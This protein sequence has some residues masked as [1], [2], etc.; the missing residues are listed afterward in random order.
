[1]DLHENDDV[2]H[3]FCD[4][5]ECTRAH[6]NDGWARLLAEQVAT[7][8]LYVDPHWQVS[9]GVA[10]LREDDLD[11]RAWLVEE[12]GSFRPLPAWAAPTPELI[13]SVRQHPHRPGVTGSWDVLA[14]SMVQ[15]GKERVVQPLFGNWGS[16]GAPDEE[17]AGK[18]FRLAF[19]VEAS[20][21]RR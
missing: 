3:P 17:E 21:L 4:D 2:A 20:S 10:H 8:A 1:M 16:E 13:R 9:I 6:F 11:W 12:D 19:G 5:A 18:L 15:R 7:A 14:V